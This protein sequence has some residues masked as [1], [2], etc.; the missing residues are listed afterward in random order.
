[1][2]DHGEKELHARRWKFGAYRI[3]LGVPLSSK[4]VTRECARDP[5]AVLIVSSE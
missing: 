3:G 2:I 4:R 5:H 1:M